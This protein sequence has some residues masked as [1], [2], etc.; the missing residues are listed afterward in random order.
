M[1]G[2]EEKFCSKQRE[3]EVS[4]VLYFIFYKL[5]TSLDTFLGVHVQKSLQSFSERSRFF[6]KVHKFS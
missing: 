5:Y 1:D 3:S 6:I 2:G 4:V